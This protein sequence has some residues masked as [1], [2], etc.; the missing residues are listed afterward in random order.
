M[1]KIHHN[2]AQKSRNLVDC[3]PQSIHQGYFE[4]I[5]I[6]YILDKNIFQYKQ[7]CQNGHSWRDSLNIS[8]QQIQSHI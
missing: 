5:L 1:R 3:G 6:Q 7:Y 8:T 2:K 4:G